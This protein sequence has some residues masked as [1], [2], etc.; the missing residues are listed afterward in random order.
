MK[1]L[2]FIGCGHLAKCL[3]QG[4]SKNT[5]FQISGFDLFQ[6]SLEWLESNGH[7]TLNLQDCCQQSDIIFL[8]VK[9]QDM[10]TLCNDLKQH[11][12]EG[13]EVVSVAA[14]IKLEKLK[15]LLPGA[16]ITRVM[17]NVGTRDNL[18]VTAIFSQKINEDIVSLFNFLG[19]AFLVD[20]ED[21]IDLHTVLIGSGPAFFY[22]LLNEFED[23]MEDII[24]D[25]DMKREITILFLTSIISAIK[26]GENLDTLVDSV[27]SKGGTTEAGLKFLREKNFNSIFS[28]AVDK[29]VERAKQ[30]S[31]D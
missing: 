24:D 27:A 15:E 11:L 13:Q 21:Q 30:L 12:K 7:K 10:P 4:L 28:E 3:I 14:G 31:M 6:G 1:N 29:G 20:N 2:S 5:E 8:C 17:T 9:P 22:D 25:K 26:N 19:K 18:G 16:N 23:K